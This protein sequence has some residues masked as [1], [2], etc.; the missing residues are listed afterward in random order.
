M[1]TVER[2]LIMSDPSRRREHTRRTQYGSRF[3]P[4]FLQAS[5]DNMKTN[6]SSARSVVG[7]L[8]KV[9]DRAT[10]GVG[11]YASALQSV[12]RPLYRIFQP[13]RYLAGISAIIGARG[14]GVT[15]S[16]AGIAVSAYVVL[17]L[18]PSGLRGYPTASLD[19]YR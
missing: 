2:L 12:P 17:I 1:V 3:Y 9:A 19:S 15:R 7:R 18:P 13:S 10:L 6:S 16:T 4:K 5:R 11:Q 14:K 8:R